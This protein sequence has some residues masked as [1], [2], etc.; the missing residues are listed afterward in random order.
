MISACSVQMKTR[1]L[2]VEPDIALN[3]KS[4]LF[5]TFP[6][7]FTGV[8]AAEALCVQHNEQNSFQL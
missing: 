5:K 2:W 8:D 7:S 3:L 1:L 6:L 4:L